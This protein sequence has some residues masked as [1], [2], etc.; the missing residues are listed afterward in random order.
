MIVTVTL[1]PSVDE[2]YLLPE[3]EPGSWS[4]ALSSQRTPGGKGINVALILS[5]MGYET[6]TMGFLA[7]FNGDYIRDAL[8]RLKITTNFVH[9]PGETRTNVYI[10]DQVGQVETGISEAG[11]SIQSDALQRFIVSYR[12]MLNRASAIVLGGS[13]PPQI[14]Q[15]IYRDL[16]MM[17]KAAGLPV[18]IDAAGPEFLAGAD[19]G[20]FFAKVD[21]RFVSK[22][23]SKSVDSLDSMISTLKDMREMGIQWVASSYHIFGDVFLTPQGLYLA[24]VSEREETGSLLSAGDALMAGFVVACSENMSVE[25]SIRFSMACAAENSTHVMKGIASREAVQRRLADISLERLD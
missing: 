15:D 10:I 14:P 7:G 24:T 19:A 25:E 18:Y 16:C 8:R 17:A 9:V 4:R 6:A 5:Q 20:P 12:R 23:T 1:N 2:E 3:F 22:L 13:L 21:H 11:P